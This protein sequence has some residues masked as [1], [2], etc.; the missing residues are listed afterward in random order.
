METI[1]MKRLLRQ[2][3]AKKRIQLKREYK[4]EKMP[5]QDGIKKEKTRCD[6]NAIQTQIQT[7]S[8]IQIQKQTQIITYFFVIGI[9]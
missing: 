9:N 4:I 3:I 1:R 6:R 7:H 8:Q 2:S 5:R